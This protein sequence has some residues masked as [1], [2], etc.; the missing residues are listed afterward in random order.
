MH[1]EQDEGDEKLILS[2][3]MPATNCPARDKILAVVRNSARESRPRRGRESFEGRREYPC[4]IA[5]FLDF[6]TS[7]LRCSR[8]NNG[9]CGIGTASSFNIRI[10][11]AVIGSRKI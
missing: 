7:F 4:N 3:E 11:V 8:K 5:G 10:N 2:L 9:V 6:R 1:R